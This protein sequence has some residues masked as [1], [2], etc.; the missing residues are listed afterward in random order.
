MPKLLLMLI[1]S[2][3]NTN[4]TTI[5]KLS[6]A[7][8]LQIVYLKSSC[9]PLK[10][11]KHSKLCTSL[12][13]GNNDVNSYVNFWLSF[14]ARSVIFSIWHEGLAV[15]IANQ[16]FHF[17]PASVPIMI[18]FLMRTFDTSSGKIKF[19]IHNVCY[20]VLEYLT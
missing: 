9:R 4:C 13:Q 16:T 20:T 3:A 10:Q 5:E 15:T 19:T 12:G 11:K 14:L 6:L 8:T 1:W 17:I 2:I 18:N 7:P